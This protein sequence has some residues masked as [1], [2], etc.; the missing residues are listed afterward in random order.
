MR[1]GAFVVR[2]PWPG[3]PFCSHLFDGTSQGDAGIG[4]G[5]LGPADGG[6]FPAAGRWRVGEERL[7]CRVVGRLGPCAADL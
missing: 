3:I 7:Q 2:G 6:R 4:W 5:E 1:S